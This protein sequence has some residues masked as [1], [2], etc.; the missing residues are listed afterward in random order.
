[1]SELE[2][3]PSDGFGIPGD[4]DIQDEIKMRKILENNSSW[5]F[6]FTKN[7]DPKGIDIKFFKWEFVPVDDWVKRHYGYIELERADSDGWVT[8]NQ[9]QYE[10]NSIDLCEMFPDN[11]IWKNASTPRITILKRKI[12]EYDWDR[13]T[14]TNKP[15][16]N[17]QRTV[18]VKFD[19]SMTE[20]FAIPLVAIKQE[21][22]TTP[23]SDDTVYNESMVALRADH[24]DVYIGLENVMAFLDEFMQYRSDPQ[25]RLDWDDWGDRM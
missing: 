8:E 10:P 4:Y 15:K 9:L 5:R 21:G 14:F 24:G 18:F 12:F 17:Y 23:R 2:N 25:S 19:H 22:R 13:E 7:P 6:E 11:W 1:M 20:C 16:S 3:N